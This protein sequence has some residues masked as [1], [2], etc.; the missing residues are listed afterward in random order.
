M[1]LASILEKLPFFRK[2]RKDREWSV[3]LNVLP[4]IVFNADKTVTVRNIRNFE[5]Q[6]VTEYTPQYYDRTYA[7]EDIRRVWFMVE[8][9]SLLAAHTLLSFELTDGSYIGISVEIRKQKGQKFSQLL[10]LGFVRR[11]ELMYVIGDEHDLIR[12]RTNHREDDVFF[13]P[14]TMTSKEAQQLFVD[15]LTRA[16]TLQQSPEFYNPF[17]NTCLTNIID[18]LNTTTSKRI[19]WSFKIL[20]ATFSDHLLYT[21]GLLDQ[22]LPFRVL[23]KKSHINKRAL[24]HRDGEN[25]SKIIRTDH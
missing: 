20:V 10:V 19:P 2:P 15:M 6:S 23:K 8:P 13:Y 3:D 9:F 24:T 12:L 17:T 25:F 7:V 5:Y 1:T 22:S 14:L 4:E 16:Q 18:H 11:H 21:V